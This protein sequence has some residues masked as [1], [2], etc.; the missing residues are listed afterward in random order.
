M[1]DGIL[2]E[3]AFFFAFLLTFTLC[4]IFTTFALTVTVRAA[5]QDLAIN[6]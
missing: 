1:T 4:F 3:S 2:L 5:W 6:L